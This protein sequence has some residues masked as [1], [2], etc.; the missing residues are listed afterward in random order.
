MAK[1]K[2]IQSKRT[3]TTVKAV[4]KAPSKKARKKEDIIEV[5]IRAIEDKKGHNAVC[6]DLRKVDGAATDYFVVCHGT[7]NTQVEAIAK[8]IEVEVEKALG[9]SPIHTEGYKNA[10][11]VLLDYFN[12]VV[13]V[14]LEEKRDFYRIEKLWADAEMLKVG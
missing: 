10:E 2:E 8:N 14:F 5:I 9:E 7:S 3:I 12:V 13:H 6:M 4:K 1:T 11:W